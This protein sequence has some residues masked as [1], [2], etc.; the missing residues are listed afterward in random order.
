MPGEG[1]VIKGLRG[2]L[3]KDR[4]LFIKT[5]LSFIIILFATVLIIGLIFN[6]SFIRYS[7]DEI[8][9]VSSG[10]LKV[11]EAANTMLVDGVRRDALRLSLNTYLNNI[12]LNLKK[13]DI[14]REWSDTVNFMNIL[15]VLDQVVNANDAIS[16][17]YIYLED[18]QQVISSK[19]GV[20]TVDRFY[21]TDWLRPYEENKKKGLNAFSI[22]TRVPLNSEISQNEV[23]LYSL[24]IGNE[25]VITYTFPLSIYTTPL[26]GAI[27]IN[28]REA[29]INQLVKSKNH[30]NEGSIF[31]ITQEGDVV[32]HAD[33]SLVGEN[34]SDED[35][36]RRIME[37]DLSEGHLLT[38]AGGDKQVVTYYKPDK[39][40][41]I[42]IGVFSLGTLMNK[43]VYLC[44]NISLTV[45]L[46]S[47]M[48]FA[49]SYLI[50]RRLYS[51]VN[52]LIQNIKN[53]KSIDVLDS[54]NEVAVLTRAF[55]TLIR[56]EKN[57]S[58]ILESNRQNIR[59]KY[60]LNLANGGVHREKT[61][62]VTFPFPYFA[63][64][65][66]CIDRYDSFSRSFAG[67]Q[68]YY[69]KTVLINICED[70]LGG[71]LRCYGADMEKERIL[72]VINIKNYQ[73]GATESLLAQRFCKI[74]QE[75]A[76]ILENTISI[77]IGNIY[78]ESKSIKFSYA[79][80]VEALSYRML[81]GYSAILENRLCTGG[82]DSKYYYPIKYEKNLITCLMNGSG[83]GVESA[84][85]GMVQDIKSN[86]NL[87]PDNV[88]LIFNQLLGK[89]LGHLLSLNISLSSVFGEKYNI[90]RQLSRKETLEEIEEWLIEILNAVIAYSESKKANNKLYLDRALAYIHQNFRMDIDINTMVEKTG[91]SYS[92]LRRV[93]VAELGVNIVNY[94]NNLRV[95]EAKRQLLQTDMNVIDIA[96]S[97]GYNNDQSFNRFFKKFAG[98]TPGE[99]RSKNRLGSSCATQ[100]V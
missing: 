43:V 4:P 23:K 55:E 69:M 53:S 89:I 97:L 96:L 5:F 36:I 66:L 3:M 24:N 62:D 52:Q 12:S 27:I 67:E 29:A 64:A 91:I 90:Y 31:I 10:K 44:T 8:G 6:Y 70:V 46:L 78:T 74:Q 48:S 63:C 42:Y 71:D 72:L 100:S 15:T 22:K 87:S 39:S 17:I 83:S 81:R 32:T 56:Q 20:D 93:F 65:V 35:Y 94:I 1:C 49:A 68:R 82:N 40:G 7:E 92:R 61:A 19:T 37:S 58:S 88:V 50:S 60:L 34:V 33:K 45:L 21:D 30:E 14:S 13:T 73:P 11:I 28:V 59:S 57:L 25:K 98:I 95:E 80:A 99:F 54:K 2:E 9:K 47:V 75:V 76:R 38:G 86:K 79:D 84:V 41:W 51:P 77:G 26:N 85:K 18:F 16:S